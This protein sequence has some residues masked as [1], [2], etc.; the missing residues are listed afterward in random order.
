MYDIWIPTDCCVDDSV[1]TFASI[2]FDMSHPHIN[3]FKLIVG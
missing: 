3:Y 2:L 1:A